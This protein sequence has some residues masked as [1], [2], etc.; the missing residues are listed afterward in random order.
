MTMTDPRLISIDDFDYPLPDSLIA[1]HPLAQRDACRLMVRHADG[2][3]EE[4]IFSDLPRLLSPDDMLV[5]NNTRVINARLRF[6]KG[7]DEHGA[8]I[9]VFCL[10]LCHR[11]TMSARSRRMAPARGVVLSAT[12]RSGKM[13]Q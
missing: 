3:L 5:I 9:G 10:D 11:P 13:G 2:A 8:R 7:S 12:A 1:R 6:R 4:R